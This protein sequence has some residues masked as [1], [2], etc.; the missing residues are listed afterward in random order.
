MNKYNN[1]EKKKIEWMED[2][3]SCKLVVTNVNVIC[4]QF[5]L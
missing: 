5:T 1:F 2:N 3:V 4:S